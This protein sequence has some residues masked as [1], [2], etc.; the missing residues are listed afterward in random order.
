[1]ENNQLPLG[2]YLDNNKYY[3]ESVLGSGG[4]GI[5]YF[6][7]DVNLK[8]KVA[9]KEFFMQQN[10]FRNP[11][12][13]N[14]YPIDAQKG[15]EFERMKHTFIEEGQVL[16]VLGEQP[17]VVNVYTFFQENNTAYLVMD[18]VQGQ[19]LSECLSQANGRITVSQALGI[20]RPVIRAL[21]GVHR[22]GVVHRDISPD[23][24]M[25]TYDNK[26]KLIDFGAARLYGDY[27]SFKVQ[28]LGYS[29]I[30]QVT[31][32]GQVGPYSDI[33]ALCATIYYCITGMK[34]P[35]SKD[36][37]LNDT[38]IAPSQCGV[39]IN[40]QTEAVLMQGLA[41]YPEQR[42][43]DAASL[44]YYLYENNNGTALV[45]MD[46]SKFLS[47]LKRDRKKKDKKK[48]ILAVCVF[49]V[50]LAAGGVVF[51]LKNPF[52][53]GNDKENTAYNTEQYNNDVDYEAYADELYVLIEN[54]HTENGYNLSRFE[55]Y[56]QAAEDAAE[57]AA[58]LDCAD[59][60]E[61]NESLALLGND[62]LE[63]YQIPNAGWVIYM[64]SLKEDVELIK[65]G[66]DSY[67]E[68]INA[69]N[70]GTINLD[71]CTYVGVSV[72]RAEDGTFFWAL[73]YR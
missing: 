1:M 31:Q 21:G 25:I 19:S 51:F 41:L 5:T 37:Q 17:G 56:Q 3:I 23:N 52:D 65:S 71:N 34:V 40:P 9:I 22:Q 66:I 42:I 63:K 4:F 46:M 73:F 27:N 13:T 47:D 8:R 59:I 33:Y 58:E 64:Y 49:C 55:E 43:Q 32:H 72:S 29:P 7:Y 36:R 14:V 67:I 11:G 18:Y 39:Y 2:T 45:N 15:E 10:C 38:L 61:L 24:I 53:R 57:Q 44:Y 54:Q 28:K 26:V 50:V 35:S 16:A 60:D 62:V 70:G 48:N 30:E 69:A 20:M 68:R 12:D 6:G